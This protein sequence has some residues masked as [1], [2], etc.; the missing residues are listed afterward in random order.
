MIIVVAV[1]VGVLFATGIFLILQRTLTRIILGLT[2]MSNGV[3][4]LLMLSGGRAGAAPFTDRQ[5]SGVRLA[6]PMPQAMVL[7]AIVI[8]FAMV[9]FLLAMAYRSMSLT[10]ADE[11]ED[12]LEDRRIALGER[13]E[14][15][16]EE[17]APDLVEE[18]DQ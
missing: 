18:R 13:V 7:T 6:D 14:E 9:S 1:L 10:G 8:N 5:T 4:M 3:S 11:V 16:Y 17:I 2:T 12:D 15:I